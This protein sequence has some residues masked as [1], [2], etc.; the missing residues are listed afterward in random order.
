MSA[1]DAIQ[2]A[3]ALKIRTSLAPL[4]TTLLFVSAD[5]EL[6]NV[7]QTLGLEVEIPTHVHSRTKLR[8]SH[9]TKACINYGCFL[10][11]G[12]YSTIQS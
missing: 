10:I 2:L 12:N 7:A 6:L 5:I 8:N 11:C 1:Y 4:G 3:C 9:I